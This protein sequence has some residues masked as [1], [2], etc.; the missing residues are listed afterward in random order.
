V[1]QFVRKITAPATTFTP[2]NI[3]QYLMYLPLNF[4]PFVGTPIFLYLQGKNYGAA[5]HDRY[6]QLNGVT[7]EDANSSVDQS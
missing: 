3:I 7:P 4:I 2:T 1:Q 6:F 5:A